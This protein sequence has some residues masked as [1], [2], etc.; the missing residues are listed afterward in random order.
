MKKNSRSRNRRNQVSKPA[1]SGNEGYMRDMQEIKFSN[2]AQPH[3]SDKD[4]RRKPKHAG[5]GWE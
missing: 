2:A 5:R 1:K 4:Y 3:R